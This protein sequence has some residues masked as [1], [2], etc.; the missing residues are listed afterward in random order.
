MAL[1]FIDDLKG[2]AEDL[3]N[4]VQEKVAE[5]SDAIN[6]GIQKA[7]DFIDE[8]TGGKFAGGVDKVQGA[9]S[10]LVDKLDGDK[11]ADPQA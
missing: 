6:D 4:Q 1:S 10:G 3:K 7:G 11:G 5:N 8:K 9:A 2:K